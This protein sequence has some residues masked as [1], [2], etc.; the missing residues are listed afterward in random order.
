MT[1]I[2]NKR[3]AAKPKYNKEQMKQYNKEATNYYEKNK[4]RDMQARKQKN[5]IKEQINKQYFQN[6]R[7]KLKLYALANKKH[8]CYI[9]NIIILLPY[10]S[11]HEAT[12]KHL[13]MI[14][15]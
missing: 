7:E 12:N 9:C 1:V 15:V 6:N 13:K 8:V 10:K 5:E 3:M 11:R 14:A 4:E 2:Y